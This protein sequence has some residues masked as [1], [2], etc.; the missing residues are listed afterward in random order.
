MKSEWK[1]NTLERVKMEGVTRDSLKYVFEF[2]FICFSTSAK[3]HLAR[4]SSKLT[5]N[6]FFLH[7][8]GVKPSWLT[9]SF[10]WTLSSKRHIQPFLWLLVVH[11]SFFLLW[12]I[13]YDL[14]TGELRTCQER[15]KNN[16]VIHFGERK[17]NFSWCHGDKLYPLSF[18]FFL[19]KLRL[20]LLS[21]KQTRS[22]SHFYLANWMEFREWLMIFYSGWKSFSH[23]V[24]GENLFDLWP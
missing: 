7:I 5:G 14:C 15:T 22:L 17:A 20:W 1:I 9:S 8:D 10:S 16:K 4:V 23:F 21:Q 19:T 11:Q 18:I 6:I 13:V 24:L 3:P 12:K 2:S